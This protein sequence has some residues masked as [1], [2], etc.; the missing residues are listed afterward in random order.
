MDKI[1]NF[2]KTNKTFLILVFI[3]ICLLA[4]FCDRLPKTNLTIY[5]FLGLFIYAMIYSIYL[6]K[7]ELTIG[8]AGICIAFISMPF[9]TQELELKMNRQQFLLEKQYEAILNFYTQISNLNENV[10]ITTWKLE[11]Y[12]DRRSFTDKANAEIKLCNLIKLYQQ[13]PK[14]EFYIPADVISISRQYFDKNSLYITLSKDFIYNPSFEKL[15][16]I[17]D[18]EKELHQKYNEF[19]IL[20]KAICCIDDFSSDVLPKQ[21]YKY[22][23]YL[24]NKK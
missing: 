15:K 4:V 11:E 21:N 10:T 9:F 17:Q 8:L 3:F 1:K 24:Q 13:M 18:T 23:K 7:F 12:Y 19:R 5:I 14:N 22:L 6:K 16:T 2:L 20:M